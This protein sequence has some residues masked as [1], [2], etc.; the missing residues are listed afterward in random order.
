MEETGKWVSSN[1]FQV[2]SIH[3]RLTNL[4]GIVLV[5]DSSTDAV[6]LLETARAQC[7]LCEIQKQLADQLVQCNLL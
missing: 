2:F 4:K 7:K 3:V 6:L 5:P 1:Y